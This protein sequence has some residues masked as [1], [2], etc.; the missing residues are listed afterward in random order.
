MGDLSL[1]EQRKRYHELESSVVPWNVSSKDAPTVWLPVPWLR[2]IRRGGQGNR[3]DPIEIILSQGAFFCFSKAHFVHLKRR[4]SKA[5]QLVYVQCV[6]R[7]DPDLEGVDQAPCSC[8][9]KYCFGCR[10]SHEH[11]SCHGFGRFEL[12]QHNNLSGSSKMS[13]D[14]KFRDFRTIQ[15]E[16]DKPHGKSK[17]SQFESAKVALAEHMTH[18]AKRCLDADAQPDGRIVQQI[19]DDK[20]ITSD[21]ASS[22][23]SSRPLMQKKNMEKEQEEE[24]DPAVRAAKAKRASQNLLTSL[25]EWFHVVICDQCVMLTAKDLAGIGWFL[26]DHLRTYLDKYADSLSL[27]CV[28]PKAFDLMCDALE[29]ISL[30]RLTV[31]MSLMKLGEQGTSLLSQGLIRFDNLTNLVLHVAHN[32]LGVSGAVLL[33]RGLDK[34]CHL[35]G[36]SIHAASNDIQNEGSIALAKAVRQMSNLCRLQIF[37]ADN[38]IGNDGIRAW[39]ECLP[40]LKQLI[41]VSFD[42]RENRLTA[43]KFP[44]INLVRIRLVLS[45]NGFQDENATTLVSKLLQ[46]E[47][48][49]IELDFLENPI[50]SGWKVQVEKAI[51][52]REKTTFHFRL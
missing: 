45:N 35:E 34:L 50:S 47:D 37:L 6:L 24:D 17:I 44:S 10:V 14:P 15:A 2:F 13:A 8:C 51:R 3:N 28:P 7:R 33:S 31:N 52:A 11:R 5:T 23:A 42:L 25:Q 46:F 40:T 39:M 19:A 12:S 38:N 18:G 20:L 1:K 41:C 48:T 9:H 43:L 49:V 26:F 29:G 32:Y 36:L 21:V 16:I 4:Q 22:D 27:E 30:N